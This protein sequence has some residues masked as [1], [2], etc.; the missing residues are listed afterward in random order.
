MLNNAHAVRVVLRARREG[1][2]LIFKDKEE[3]WT[4]LNTL[5]NDLSA[6][7]AEGFVAR[8]MG[9]PTRS[10][11]FAIGI[12]CEE[13]P[14]L[15][16]TKFRVMIIAWKLLEKIE[17]SGDIQF[18]QPNHHVRLATLKQ[19]WQIAR[20]ERFKHNIMRVEFSVRT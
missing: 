7:S 2:V 1:A 8:S 15:K 6:V 20:D 5:L 18:E 12:T 9:L 10:E 14:D 13:H 17:T 3:A 11:A 19:M 4:I 16:I